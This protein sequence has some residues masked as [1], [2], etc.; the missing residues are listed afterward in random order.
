MN[1]IIPEKKLRTLSAFQ[2][3][4]ERSELA[5]YRTPVFPGPAPPHRTTFT[6][7]V[8]P[9]RIYSDNRVAGFQTRTVPSFEEEA[10]RGFEGFLYS[11][12]EH[13]T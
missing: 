2:T 12:D 3:F 6:L 8:C 10:R 1:P 11:Q 4:T 7:A 9:P 5:V 13:K